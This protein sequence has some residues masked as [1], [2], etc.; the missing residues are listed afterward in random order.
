[1]ILIK[2]PSNISL[3]SIV[4]DG[5][6][7]K[8]HSM[9][10]CFMTVTP[11]DDGHLDLPDNLKVLNICYC[12]VASGPICTIELWILFGTSIALFITPY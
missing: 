12:F 11:H 7:L 1:M 5:C 8:T 4:F 6:L 2:E 3:G 9:A 10:G